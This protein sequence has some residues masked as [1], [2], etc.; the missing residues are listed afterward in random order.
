MDI[1]KF[2]NKENQLIE[3]HIIPRAF[4]ETIK[5]NVGKGSR[6][7]KLKEVTNAKGVY[8]YRD[9]AKG[10]FDNNLLCFDCEKLF[11]KIDDYGITLLLKNDNLQTP[12]HSNG[13]LLAWIIESYDYK[14]LMLFFISILWRAGASDMKEFNNVT[15][16]PYLQ[17]AKDVI[18]TQN[19]DEIKTFS[20]V[21][22]RFNYGIGRNI[23]L[24]PHMEIK[25]NIFSNINV[26]RFYLGA[27]YVVH[28]KTDKRPF[29]TLFEELELSNRGSLIILSRG[30]FEASKELNVMQK[31]YQD[32]KKL[33][34][35]WKSRGRDGS[36]I[37]V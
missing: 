30:N 27:G 4:F 8:P 3:A 23:F 26:Y 19:L 14:K 11:S 34:E 9:S 17:V 15:L 2:C 36:I 16:G 7:Q 20:V 12:H 29:P 25:K 28:I 31:V 10:L 35:T 18:N 37:Y 6:G 13:R 21:L 22:T 24:N 33:S 5:T 32:A 1:C